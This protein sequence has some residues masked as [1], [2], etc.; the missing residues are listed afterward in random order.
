MAGPVTASHPIPSKRRL[1]WSYR[2]STRRALFALVLLAQ[3]AVLLGGV[4]L[5]DFWLRREMNLAPRWADR[6]MIFQ[7]SVAFGV[8]LM[9]NATLFLASRR[10]Q[11]AIERANRDLKSEVE[12]QVAEGLAKR[13]A[14]IFGLAKLADYRDTDTGAHLE[15]IGRYARLLADQLRTVHTEIDDAWTERLVLASS[16]HDIGKVG[17]PDSILLKPGSLTPE[18]REIMQTHTLIGADTLMA[19]RQKMGADPFLDMGV[20]IAMQH[21]EKW[22]GTGYP[23]GLMGETISL[24]ARI[25]A[26]ADFYDAVT[27]ERVYKPAMPHEEAHNLIL[28]LRGSHFDPQVVD[29]Y[30]AC[31]ARFD[32]IRRSS[33]SEPKRGEIDGI[34]Q[35]ARRYMAE[36]GFPRL[37]A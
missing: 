11:D 25:V 4:L 27:S 14:L 19:I 16:L 24:A 17:I 31:A 35:V 34:E 23:F 33:R 20:E 1:H 2:P 22:D 8:F 10:Y 13:D 5:V 36:Q 18:E 9:T 15:R 26:M 37:V 12:R 32:A 30:L 29:A 6:L 3:A 28:S 21:H 7:L